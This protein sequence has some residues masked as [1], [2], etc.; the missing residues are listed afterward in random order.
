MKTTKTLWATRKVG[1]RLTI[2]VWASFEEMEKMYQDNIITDY[3]DAKYFTPKD[4]KKK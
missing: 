1:E 2:L 3:T 4:L